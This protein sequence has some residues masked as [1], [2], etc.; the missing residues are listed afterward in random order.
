MHKPRLD[1]CV[2]SIDLALAIRAVVAAL[3]LKVPNGN[4]QFRCPECDYAVKPH[5]EEDAPDGNA[6]H[7]EHLPGHPAD[8]SRS[9]KGNLNKA[10]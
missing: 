7:F 9:R 4:L 2:I 5:N 1:E 8:C 6:P 10:A 3:E